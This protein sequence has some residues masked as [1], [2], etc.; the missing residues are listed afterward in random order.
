MTNNL[1]RGVQ[2]EAEGV[3]GVRRRL[4]VKCFVVPCVTIGPDKVH[5]ANRTGCM[6]DKLR[7]APDRRVL[8]HPEDGLHAALGSP[9]LLPP[10]QAYDI[11]S[12]HI[13]CRN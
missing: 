11:N 12:C 9:L 1:L 2:S 13:G 6:A 7:V 4:L 10:H 5:K 8:S 3:G